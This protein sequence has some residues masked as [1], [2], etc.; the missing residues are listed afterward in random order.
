[1]KMLDDLKESKNG[2]FE[3]YSEKH[4]LTHKSCL[5]KL[6]YAKALILSHTIDLMHQEH[7]VAESIISMCF[8][9]TDFLKDNISARKDLTTL[10]SCHSLEAERNAKEN[11]TRPHAPYYLKPAER[12]EILRW[13]KKLKFSNRYASNIKR[14]VNVNTDKLNGL[15]SHDCHIIIEIFMPVI[16]CGYFNVICGRYLLNSTTSINIFVLKKSQKR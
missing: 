13:V 4:N 1:M 9:V 8:D 12:K 15:N 5:W 11:L 10:C 14:A 6:S 16:F 2:G 3:G 7:N